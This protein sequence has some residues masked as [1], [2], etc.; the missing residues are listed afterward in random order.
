MLLGLR[1]HAVIGR[2][3]QKRNV[4]A[5]RTSDHL[6]HEALVPR[7]VHHAHAL[8]AGQLKLREAQL[9]GDAALLFSG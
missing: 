6:P 3:A 1:H 5:G 8:A 9:D 4:N 2:D 7:N